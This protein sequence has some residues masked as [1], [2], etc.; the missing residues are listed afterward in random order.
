MQKRLLSLVSDYCK[1]ETLSMDTVAS[2]MAA[3]EA[4]HRLNE[5]RISICLNIT[6]NYSLTR[7]RQRNHM[8]L[9][10][11]LTYGV[12]SGPRTIPDSSGGDDSMGTGVS[13]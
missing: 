11:C 1:A 9:H 12:S 6:T 2:S 4:L 10:Q 13:T 7:T 3:E 5:S 8:S